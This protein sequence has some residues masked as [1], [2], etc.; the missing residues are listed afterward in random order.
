MNK[1]TRRI[2]ISIIVILIVLVVAIIA[3]VNT[4]K[5][6]TNEPNNTTNSA[7]TTQELDL[8]SDEVI[9]PKNSYLFFEKY[10]NGKVPSKEIYQ[11]IYKYANSLYS[12]AKIKEMSFVDGSFF[13]TTEY[14]TAKLVITYNDKH[15]ENANIKVY[16]SVQSNKSNV[17]FT[18]D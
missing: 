5:P 6:E 4:G 17:E 2:L 1:K 11:E 3:L 12:Q 8:L 9:V 7:Q 13:H 15:K 10:K 16:K 14:T 18:Q